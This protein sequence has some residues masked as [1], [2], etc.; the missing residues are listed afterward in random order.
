M[1]EGWRLTSSAACRSRVAKPCYAAGVN[2][3]CD[4]K[5]A[6]TSVAIIY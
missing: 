4:S 1:A 2:A 5:Q 6:S 3:G